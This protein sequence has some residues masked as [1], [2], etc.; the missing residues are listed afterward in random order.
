MPKGCPAGDPTALA[1]VARGTRP[2]GDVQ[3]E[4]NSRERGEEMS[5]S[6]TND[7]SPSQ[8]RAAPAATA[9]ARDRQEQARVAFAEAEGNND[10][11]EGKYYVVCFELKEEP[12]E[13]FFTLMLA[14]KVRIL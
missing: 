1:P 5:H 7:G 8:C 4:A 14:T 9:R 2:P 13:L 12:D 11:E 3:R 10:I 6:G